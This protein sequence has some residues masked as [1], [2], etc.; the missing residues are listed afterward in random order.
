M[1]Q[2]S[3][4]KQGSAM[5]TT[6]IVILLM[7]SVAAFTTSALGDTSVEAG[8]EVEDKLEISQNPEFTEPGPATP[9]DMG[10]ATEL[11]K[12]IENI[13]E[14]VKEETKQE[15]IEEV[16]TSPELT[17]PEKEDVTD[18]LEE[19]ILTKDEIIPEQ[20]VPKI[21]DVLIKPE[22][23][24]KEIEE[25]KKYASKLIHDI[26][27]RWGRPDKNNVY[28]LKGDHRVTWDDLTVLYLYGITF[29]GYGFGNLNTPTGL[30]RDILISYKLLTE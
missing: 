30:Y 11:V 29:D 25:K 6:L 20:D 4:E 10:G 19:E 22:M 17:E 27:N 16:Q 13:G 9:E 5:I 18:A 24:P 1:F 12:D 2:K 8:K 14:Q 28:Q 21:E 3:K 23:T 7:S 15:I 26:E